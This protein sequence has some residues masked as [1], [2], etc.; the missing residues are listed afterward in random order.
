MSPNVLDIRRCPPLT[1]RWA[2]WV[3]FCVGM[4]EATDLAKPNPRRRSDS[5]AEAYIDC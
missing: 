5:E 4:S 1:E 2:M 3:R